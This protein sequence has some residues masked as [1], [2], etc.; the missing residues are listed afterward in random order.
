MNKILIVLVTL[1]MGFAEVVGSSFELAS[2]SGV[3]FPDAT[4]YSG[5]W[6]EKQNIVTCDVCKQ[7]QESAQEYNKETM[8][9]E[10]NNSLVRTSAIYILA[11]KNLKCESI[12]AFATKTDANKGETTGLISLY[13]K[14]SETSDKFF[15]DFLDGGQEY[16]DNDQKD[17]K[18]PC[19]TIHVFHFSYVVRQN[20]EFF[21]E[22][23]PSV[24]KILKGCEKP[25][26]IERVILEFCKIDSMKISTETYNLVSES[27]QS[28]LQE[29]V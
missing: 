23:C 3:F 22:I 8:R 6:L 2:K 24:W 10:N 26:K 19:S 27:I 15:N 13:S 21:F 12:Y 14:N 1:V 20:K 5:K 28:M 11:N 7:F 17:T 18:E 16:L 9:S 25:K 29:K 4:N